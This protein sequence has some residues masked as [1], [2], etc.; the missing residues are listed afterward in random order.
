MGLSLKSS[1]QTIVIVHVMGMSLKS[2]YQTMVIVQFPANVV[3]V[4]VITV[5][6]FSVRSFLYLLKRPCG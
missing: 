3:E 1:Y 2:S 5:N 6:A 4:D